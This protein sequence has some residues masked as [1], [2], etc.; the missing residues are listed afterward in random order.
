MDFSAVVLTEAQQ[1]FAEEVRAL[2][3]ELLTPAVYAGMRE[4]ADSYDEGVYLA[5]GARG[6]LEPR[7]L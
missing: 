4:R 3:D 5:V 6:W 7:W 1:A 2:L